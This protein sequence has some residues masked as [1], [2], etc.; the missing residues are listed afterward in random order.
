M[1]QYFK[2][3]TH[4]AQTKLFKLLLKRKITKKLYIPLR[5]FTILHEIFYYVHIMT[6]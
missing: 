4:Q 3:Y 2:S 5:N 6:L 1:R